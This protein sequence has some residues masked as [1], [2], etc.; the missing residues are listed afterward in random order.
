M[1][2]ATAEL[3]RSK[4]RFGLLTMGAGLLVFVLL[5]QQS[6]LA[7]VLDGMAGAI[8]QQS[9]PVI[10][11]TKEA[12]RSLG[13]GLVV[14]QQVTQVAQVPGVADV[15]GLGM[16]LLS[17]QAP[18]SDTRTNVSVIG[19][20]PGKPGTPTGVREGRLPNAPDEIVASAEGAVGHFG[21]GDPLIFDPGGVSLKVVGLTE[22]ALL[23]IGP[24]LWIPWESYEKLMRLTNPD[25]AFVLPSV[26]AVQP[27]AGV[28]PDQLIKDLNA[29]TPLDAVSRDVAA[30]SAPGR[31]PIQSA[32]FSVMLLCY[33]VVAVVIGFFFLTMTLQKEASITLLRAVGANSRYLIGCLLMEVGV[34]TAGGLVI[35]V[36]V[37]ILVKPMVRS[38]VIINISPAGIVATAV[39]A[40]VVA[41]LGAVP[42][43]RRVLRT[44]P[45]GVVSRP[46]LGGVG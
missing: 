36:L 37:L 16:G 18:Q 21:I 20:Q 12:K 7:A 27:T 24:A 22:S 17:F 2:F 31:K 14:P 13:A 25:S 41:L 26:L 29:Q 32:F 34:V 1:L 5:F 33:V 19:Y 39:P 45:F 11:F 46:S 23:N 8:K 10:V 38:S 43:M 9:G 6:L 42:P 15:G 40:L 4:A 3:G 28:T 35:G 44:D 30:D